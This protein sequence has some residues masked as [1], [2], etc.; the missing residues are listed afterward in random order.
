M[1]CHAKMKQPLIHDGKRFINKETMNEK[2]LLISC[3]ALALSAQAQTWDGTVAD[4]YA[5]GDGSKEQ[6]YLIATASQWA[7]FSNDVAT[8][9]GFSQGKYFLL[10]ADIVLNDSVYDGIVRSTR[11]DKEDLPKDA[12]RYR[13]TPCIGTYTSDTEY[14]AFEG[15]FDGNGHTISGMVGSLYRSQ[16]YDALFRVLQN[17]TVKNLGLTDS[18]LLSNARLGGI[19]GRVVDSRIINCYVEHSFIEGGGSQS[20]GFVGQM[21][22]TSQV[23]NCYANDVTVFGKNDMGGFIG[24]IG[25]SNE[26]PCVVDNC[27]SRISLRVKRRNHGAVSFA[28]CPGATVRNVYYERLG[29][30]TT[31]FWTGNSNGEVENVKE[32]AAAAFA[33]EDLVGSL[34]QRAAEIPGACRWK[35][36][37]DRITHDFSNFT[38]GIAIS[39]INA[40]DYVSYELYDLQG[41]RLSPLTTPPSTL[42]KGIYLMRVTDRQGRQHTM[43]ARKNTK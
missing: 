40:D 21:F 17:A 33:S 1:D 19:A 23:L 37:G 38:T 8:I 12:G 22:G 13:E 16:T 42:T 32:L 36:E 30:I 25:D 27:Y 9:A 24:R 15:T 31:D 34:N 6:P 20:G 35:V 26:N 7:K 18:Y 43:K 4:N 3:L 39:N 41:R 28:C 10:T 11:Q 29:E 14:V 5:G 2:L